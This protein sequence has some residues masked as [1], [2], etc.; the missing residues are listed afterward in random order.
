MLSKKEKRWESKKRKIQA[1]LDVAKLNE[2]E[3]EYKVDLRS[4]G[5]R[6][7]DFIS[8]VSVVDLAHLNI[9]AKLSFI[10]SPQCGTRQ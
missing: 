6:I 4:Y 2:C 3:K 1:F 9:D 7:W 8:E 5:S 10:L